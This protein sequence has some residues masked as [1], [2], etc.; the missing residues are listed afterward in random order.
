MSV[1]NDTRAPYIYSDAVNEMKE[2]ISGFVPVG[3]RKNIFLYKKMKNHEN[4]VKWPSK[5][6]LHDALG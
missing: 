3:T 1:E 5:A 4:Y 2:K 6:P